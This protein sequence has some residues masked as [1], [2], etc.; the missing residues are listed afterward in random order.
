MR[1]HETSRLMPLFLDSELSP[2]VTL[3]MEEHFESCSDC[4][5]RLEMESSLEASVRATLVEPEP[6]D[7][8]IWDRAVAKAVQSGRSVRLNMS[9]V[10][11]AV[12]AALVAAL[13]FVVIGAPHRELDLAHSAATD[14]ARFM[15]EVSEEALPPTSMHEF[16]DAGRQTLPK[17]AF[18]PATLPTGYSLV[19]TGRCKLDGAPVAYL[20]LRRGGE[21]ISVFLMPREA[22]HRFPRFAAK[23]GVEV[24]GVTCRVAGRRFFGLGSTSVVACA[25]GRADPNELRRLVRW[26]LTT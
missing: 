15:V 19:K 21:P 22:L 16:L 24:T 6:A 25:V 3:E 8:A 18:L 13:A 26:A 7:G 11:F 5:H 23:L 12:A 2:E 1:C 14:H 10:V 20:V 4:R 17:G 9:K